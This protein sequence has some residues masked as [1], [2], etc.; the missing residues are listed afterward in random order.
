M[1]LV[2]LK[3]GLFA[4][5]CQRDIDLIMKSTGGNVTNPSPLLALNCQ[6]HIRRPST[7]PGALSPHLYK[8]IGNQT[9]HNQHNWFWS[10]GTES[11]DD[12]LAKCRARCDGGTRICLPSPPPPRPLWDAIYCAFNE[13]WSASCPCHVRYHLWDAHSNLKLIAPTILWVQISNQLL[14]LWCHLYVLWDSFQLSWPLSHT[15]FF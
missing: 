9:E 12:R 14:R 7:H 15:V 10:G 4:T 1:F 6:S 5:S 11:D 13:A 3:M 2:R 8:A